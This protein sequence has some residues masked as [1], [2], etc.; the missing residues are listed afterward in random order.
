MEIT[1]CPVCGGK[2]KKVKEDWVGIF[3]DQEYVVPELE[4]YICEDCGEKIYP[5]EALK[6][7]ETYS[8]AYS[9]PTPA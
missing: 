2:V 4:Y 9:L 5:R 6:K 3:K 8:P 1:I 7:I